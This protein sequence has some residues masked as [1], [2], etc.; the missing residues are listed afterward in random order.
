MIRSYG[1]PVLDLDDGHR[2]V[3]AQNFRHQALVLRR[4]MLDDNERHPAIGPSAIE[5]GFESFDSA[6]GCSDSYHRKW[7]VSPLGDISRRHGTC[8][9]HRR[10]ISR[11]LLALFHF[12]VLAEWPPG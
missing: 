8:L 3:A 1:H 2:R 5:K 12:S 4:Q 9:R 6:G 7:Q 11:L 10:C